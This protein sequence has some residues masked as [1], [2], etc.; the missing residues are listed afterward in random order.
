MKSKKKLK[1]RIARDIEALASFDEGNGWFG[2]FC[3]FII[4]GIL[5]GLLM[6]IGG[7]FHP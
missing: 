4:G 6:S 2:A 1:A 3:G 7:H 5:S